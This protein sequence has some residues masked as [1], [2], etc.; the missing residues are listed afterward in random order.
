MSPLLHLLTADTICPTVPLSCRGDL[1]PL[2][3]WTKVT[4]SQN[5][6]SRSL[7]VMV[8]GQV[9]NR[10]FLTCLLEN[11]LLRQHLESSKQVQA[12]HPFIHVCITDSC[13]NH[14][15][16]VDLVKSSTSLEILTPTHISAICAR[17][18][19]VI[20]CSLGCK[21]TLGNNLLMSLGPWLPHLKI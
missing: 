10:S 5:R 19:W 15:S 8:T 12:P 3:L 13:F 11:G 4:V 9:T 18:L 21:Y 14:E 7:L 17:I 1:Y 16:T 20:T 6:P 2:K